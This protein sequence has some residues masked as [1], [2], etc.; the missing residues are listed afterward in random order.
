[1]THGSLGV[2]E[3]YQLLD[4]DGGDLRPINTTVLEAAA[5]SMGDSV[6]AELMRSQ[7][8]V[9]T[10]VCATLADVDRALR[11]L[12]RRLNTLAGEYGCRLGASG[13]HPSAHWET[14][15]I[16]PSERYQGMAG[17]YQQMARE[18]LIFGCHVHAGIDDLDLRIDVMNRVRAWL[19]V[20]LALSTNSPF[21]AGSDTGYG[22]YRTV[23]FRRWPTT[24]MP[25]RFDGND[26]YQHLVD[27]LVEA[28]AIDD[29]TKLYWDVRPSARFPTLE[30]RI[31]DVCLTVDDAVTITGLIAGLVE[32][33][34]QDNLAGVEPQ[35]PRHELLEAAVW[36]A[37]RHGLG[38]QLIDV[39][40][41]QLRPAHEVVTGFVTAIRAALEEAGNWER[42]SQGVERL[43]RDGTG[44][45][46]QRAILRSTGRLADVVEYIAGQTVA[47]T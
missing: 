38:G 18:T 3:E 44:A 5:P 33:A 41:G 26:E 37:A 34:R 13:T 22:S 43:L 7:I 12:R 20:L 2:E 17:Q 28:G 15:P 24:G 42:V 9:S 36:R 16:T 11:T 10:P 25:L 39:T 31:A 46:R 40:A 6:H 27:T 1:M 8:E 30:F 14:Q 23:V 29:A 35:D 4:I 21:W 19:P 32:T 47:G 45:E